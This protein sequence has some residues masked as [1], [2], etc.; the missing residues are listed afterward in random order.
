M[1]IPIPAR[2]AH[3]TASGRRESSGG[4]SRNYNK[5]AN[6]VNGR[7]H[8]RRPCCTGAFS[9]PRKA[10][11]AEGQALTR[12]TAVGE[13]ASQS[14]WGSGGSGTT[15]DTVCPRR[16][17]TV[18]LATAFGNSRVPKEMNQ[19]GFGADSHR[20]KVRRKSDVEKGIIIHCFKSYGSEFSLEF[21]LLTL[22][23][24]K[25]VEGRLADI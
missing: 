12:P 17:V 19:C 5:T 18:T 14:R 4:D 11:S 7:W 16:P 13:S 8:C 20:R 21:Y 25:D 15:N 9:S 23:P 3:L 22:S 24:A 6:P 10:C 2:S 1:Q